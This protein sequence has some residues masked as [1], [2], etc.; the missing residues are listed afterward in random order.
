[1]GRKASIQK[2]WIGPSLRFEM[3]R[4]LDFLKARYDL[5]DW[6]KTGTGEAKVALK[7]VS[8][9]LLRTPDKTSVS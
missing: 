8:S 1:M 7:P 3:R 2:R 9:F 4:T 6:E 5:I